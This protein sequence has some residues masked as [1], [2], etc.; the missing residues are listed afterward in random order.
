MKLLVLL[1]LACFSLPA[2]ANTNYQDCV[3]SGVENSDDDITVKDIKNACQQHLTPR[4]DSDILVDRRIAEQ[5]AAENRRAL[6]P[7][8]R[9][10]LLPATY[11]VDPNEKPIPPTFQSLY[12]DEDL[13]NVEMKFQLSLKYQFAKSVFMEND[14][15]HVGFTSLS[16][17]QAYNSSVSAPFRETNYEP[18]IFWTAPVEWEPLGLDASEIAIG[19][20]H[21]SNGSAGTLSRSWNRLY[22]SLSWESGNYVFNFKPWYRIREDKKSNL[23]DAK[24]DDN[25]D[26][27]KYLGH[28]EFSTIYRKENHEITMLIRNNLR[29]DNLGAI[30][31]DWTFPIWRGLKGHAQYFNGYGESLIDYNQRVERFGFG[32]LLTYFY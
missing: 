25:P 16:F 19:F 29:S 6:V 7:H 20:S 21:Q 18:E 13:D 3:L 24:G 11:A 30:Q 5:A 1:T 17:W 2:F 27:E 4:A 8:Q 26:I 28:F 12:P 32:V 10:Y 23:L 9:N 22:A 15:L 14:T 31:L